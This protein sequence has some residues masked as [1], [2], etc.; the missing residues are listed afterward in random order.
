MTNHGVSPSKKT[1]VLFHLVNPLRRILS[2]SSS[3]SNDAMKERMN[4][5][6]EQK[7]DITWWIGCEGCMRGKNKDDHRIQREA[8][9]SVCKVNRTEQHLC[10]HKVPNHLRWIGWLDLNN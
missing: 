8:S 4:I 10:L 2:T 1:V 7:S 6:R 9:C 5:M 3:T